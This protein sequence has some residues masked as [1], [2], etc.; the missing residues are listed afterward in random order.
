MVAE[1]GGT[2]FGAAAQ[3]AEAGREGVAAA[4]A[5]GP[6]W[7]ESAEDKVQNDKYRALLK[8]RACE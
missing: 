7:I 4:A 2:L 5:A 1:G 8:V 3:P 6:V